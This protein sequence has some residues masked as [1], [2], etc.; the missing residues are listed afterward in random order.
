MIYPPIIPNMS[1]IPTRSGRMSTAAI[2]LGTTRYLMGL[3]EREIR[4]SICSV[5]FIDPISAAI[6][7]E[8]LPA[9][10]RPVSTGPSSLVSVMATILGM[11]FSAPKREKPV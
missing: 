8:I 1:P 6:D 10:I 9:I 2:I 11:A 7:D 4:A 3:T 5:T